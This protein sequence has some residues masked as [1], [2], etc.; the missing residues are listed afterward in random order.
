MYPRAHFIYRSLLEERNYMK[1]PLELLSHLILAGHISDKTENTVQELMHSPKEK[2]RSG[3]DEDLGRGDQLPHKAS[4]S[5][6]TKQGRGD[7]LRAPSRTA[8]PGWDQPALPLP[9]VTQRAAE[10]ETAR[11]GV[12]PCMGRRKVDHWSLAEVRA[13]SVAPPQNRTAETHTFHEKESLSYNSGFGL[14]FHQK[15]KKKSG[16]HKIIILFVLHLKQMQE[17][18]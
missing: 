7:Q 3:R 16:F 15:K 17:D 4:L 8:Q 5:T 12:H 9:L 18:T 13:C 14:F 6:V 11:D 2:S 1:K 10:P